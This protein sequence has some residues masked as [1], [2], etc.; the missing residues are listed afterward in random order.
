MRDSFNSSVYSF[1]V[2][3]VPLLQTCLTLYNQ[4]EK[5]SSNIEERL[6]AMGKRGI[7]IKGTLPLLQAIHVMDKRSETA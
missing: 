3:Y 1:Q 2:L 7:K 6:S 5:D 4:L